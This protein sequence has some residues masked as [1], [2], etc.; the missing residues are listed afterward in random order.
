M[1][2]FPSVSHNERTFYNEFD[3]PFVDERISDIVDD[4]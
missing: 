4:M 2:I 3:T 1:N